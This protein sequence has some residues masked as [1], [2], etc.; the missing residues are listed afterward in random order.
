M[1][2]DRANSAKLISQINV[3]AFASVMVV[4][5]FA[6]MA[7]GVGAMSPHRGTSV[8]LPKVWHPVEMRHA[9]REDALVV[10]IERD[11]KVYFRNQRVTADELPAKTAEGLA[12]GSERRVYIRADA[13]AKYGDV[14]AVLDGVRSAGV[15]NVVF[16]VEQRKVRP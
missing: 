8:D 9:N 16:F 10:G 3:T 5:V 7:V 11:G 14:S 6:L 4:L 15:E 2:H 1:L 12:H 13:R